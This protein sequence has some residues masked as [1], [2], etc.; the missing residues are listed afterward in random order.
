MGEVSM[1]DKLEEII[2]QYPCQVRSRRRTRGAFLLETDQGLR[3]LKEC[4]ASQAR[5]EFE[6]KVK[7]QLIRQG[8]LL[9]DHTY[10]NSREEYFTKDNYRNNWVMRQWYTGT[11]CDIRDH[12]CVVKCAGYLGRLHTFMQLGRMEENSY[13][14]KE[15]IRQEM[16]RHNKEMKR[17]RSYIRGKK[18][19]NEMEICLLE[20][21][22]IFYGQA[23]LAQ[24]LLQECGYEE[25]WQQTLARGL[26]RHGSYTYHNVLFTGNDMAVTNFDRAEIGLQIRDLYDLLRKAMEKNSW[27]PELGRCLIETYHGERHLN[28]SEKTVLYAMLLYPEKYWKLVNF[29]YN[30]RKSWMSAKNLEK[31]LKIRSQEEQRSGFLKEAKEILM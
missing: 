7:E 30:S 19:K 8:N 5:I 2:R 26:V 14:Q 15:S 6:E 25:L 28:D 9:V 17:V 31:L 10:K 12:R 27:H 1:E 13:V 4:S 16:E 29:Y 24:S 11:E 21:F 18:Q 23:C 3:L 22:D 20:S